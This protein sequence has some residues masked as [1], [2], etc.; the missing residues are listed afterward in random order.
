[1]QEFFVNL[2][3]IS[4]TSHTLLSAKGTA[5]ETRPSYGNTSGGTMLEGTKSVATAQMVEG[6]CSL[7]VIYQ[8]TP[9]EVF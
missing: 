4:L 7:L 6:S 1:M 3:H 5:S 9:S 2:A 8:V